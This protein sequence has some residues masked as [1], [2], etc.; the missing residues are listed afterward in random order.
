M[1]AC[2]HPVSIHCAQVL[3]L[4]LDQRAGKLC[5]ITQVLGEF[6]SFEL[7]FPAEDVHQELDDCVHWRKSIGKEDEAD[8]DRELVV[9]T[10]GFVEGP[11]INKYGEKSEDIEEMSL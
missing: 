5:R 7:E 9:E 6:V 10:E 2:I 3:D 4:K 11:V 8:Y 1:V